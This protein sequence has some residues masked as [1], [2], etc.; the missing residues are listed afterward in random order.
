REPGAARPAVPAS[1][2]RPPAA[3][4]A[5]APAPAAKPAPVAAPQPAGTSRVEVT[6]VEKDGRVI[7]RTVLT[8]PEGQTTTEEV[9]R[10]APKKEEKPETK[11][12]ADTKPT[13]KK[14][15]PRAPDD[16]RSESPA[17]RARERP[18]ACAR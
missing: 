16:E 9:I 1:P 14:P 3:Q 18:R 15:A 8:G 2:A 10:D 5:P 11:K 4:P 6:Y 7:K 12:P 17:S 13:P